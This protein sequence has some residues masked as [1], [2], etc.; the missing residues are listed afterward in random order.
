M[1]VDGLQELR[2]QFLIRNARSDMAELLLRSS[3]L[4]YL[5]FLGILKG[6]RTKCPAEISVAPTGST[7]YG[8]N[9]EL[10]GLE[11]SPKLYAI[12]YN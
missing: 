1:D 11:S 7:S 9:G 6:M 8:L 5:K 3:Y 10:W 4:L 2:Y 12:R